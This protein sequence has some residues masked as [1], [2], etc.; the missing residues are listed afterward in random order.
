MSIDIG[1]YP[2]NVK[3][4]VKFFWNGRSEASTKQKEKGKKD[5]G[6]RS[7]VT[8]GK[9]LDAFAELLVDLVKKNGLKDADIHTSSTTLPGHFRATKDWDLLV[10]HKE[11]LIAAIELKSLCSPSVGKNLNNRVEEAIGLGIDFQVAAREGAFGAGR[12]PFTGFL[13]L[14]K[15]DIE[16][17]KPREGRSK[18]FSIDAEFKGASYVERLDILCDRMMKEQLF[19]AACVIATEKRKDGK[20]TDISEATGAKSFLAA[21]VSKIAEAGI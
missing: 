4:A 16:S 15:D 10:I 21:F 13:I 2:Q 8:G 11:K 5:Q 18:H 7:A 17:R 14:I 3:K 12:P 9:N 20:Y 6:N 1:N 19:D